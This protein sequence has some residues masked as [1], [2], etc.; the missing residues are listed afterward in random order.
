MV[1]LGLFSGIAFSAS[2]QLVARFANKNVIALGLGCSASGP[3]VLLLQLAL[4]MGPTPTRRQQVRCGTVGGGR[5]SRGWARC[6]RWLPECVPA[7]LPFCGAL[8]WV[9]CRAPSLRAGPSLKF[10]RRSFFSRSSG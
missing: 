4:N 3:L 5:R 1:A 10:D 2:Y 7:C 9:A 8:G 6:C